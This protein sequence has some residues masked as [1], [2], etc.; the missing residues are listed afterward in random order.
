MD[1]NSYNFKDILSNFEISGSA[2]EIKPYGS[3][4]INSTFYLKNSEPTQPDYL[5]QRI[6]NHVFP[7]VPGLINN[8]CVVIDHLKKKAVANGEDP[9]KVVLTLIP[10]IDGSFYHHD[11]AGSYWRMYLFLPDTNSY[12]EVKTVKQSFQGGKAFGKFQ[13]LLSDLDPSLL[14]ETI[15]DFHNIESRLNKLHAAIESDVVGRVK[16]CREEINFILERTSAMSTILNLGREGKLPT[17]ITHNDTKFNNVLL[18]KSDQ[19]Q[20][21]IDLDTVMPGYIAYDFGDAIRVL[22]NTAAEDEADLDRIAVDVPLFSG[23]AQGYL[24]ET[25]PFLR[26]IEISS[27]IHGVLLL[28]YMQAVRFLTDFLD[29]DNY[30]KVKFSH[31]NLQRAR[32]QLQFVKKLE[33]K[34][35]ELKTIILSIADAYKAPLTPVN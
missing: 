8:S 11:S 35:D 30:F 32:A 24:Q 25:G 31:H 5:L 18:D 9:E 3:G 6:N 20:C 21:V 33:E 7:D 12:D 15:T 22:A 28:P 13:T 29:G 19:A 16:E 17:R 23:F 34:K 27:L 10:S 2:S 1:Q 14:I 4:H 26:D